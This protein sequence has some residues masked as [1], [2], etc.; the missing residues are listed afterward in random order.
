MDSTLCRFV[1]YSFTRLPCADRSLACFS[2]DTGICCGPNSVLDSTVCRTAVEDQATSPSPQRR[3]QPFV[4]VRFSII[5]LWLCAAGYRRRPRCAG[6][7]RYFTVAV[8]QRNGPVGHQFAGLPM[9][10]A[11]EGRYDKTAQPCCILTNT[12]TVVLMETEI[13]RTVA[14]VALLIYAGGT[15]NALCDLCPAPLLDG[16]LTIPGTA[17]LQL[18]ATTQGG[19]ATLTGPL[20][21]ISGQASVT[22]QSGEFRAMLYGM[23]DGAIYRCLGT[24]DG[25]RFTGHCVNGSVTGEISGRFLAQP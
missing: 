17:T 7:R 23:S 5:C 8:W 11:V 6:A 24:I 3:P 10:P 14:F 15:G 4:G 16:T 2:Q 1:T 21:A 18:K 20:G 25:Q 22:C 12:Q 19:D 13:T 9:S